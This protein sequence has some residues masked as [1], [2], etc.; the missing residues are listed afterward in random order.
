MLYVC[1]CYCIHVIVC[2]L[3][4]RLIYVIA[5]RYTIENYFQNAALTMYLIT[6]YLVTNYLVTNYLVTNY[7]I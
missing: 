1:I 5:R 7:L 2:M 4:Y 3:V 6:N